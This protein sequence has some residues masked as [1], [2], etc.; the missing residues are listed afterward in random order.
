MLAVEGVSVA[1]YPSG[2]LV[3]RQPLNPGVRVWNDTC[4]AVGVLGGIAVTA[5]SMTAGVIELMER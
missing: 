2:S 1:N 4:F 5:P 3:S